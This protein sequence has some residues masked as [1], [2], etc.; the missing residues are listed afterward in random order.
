MPLLAFW[1]V[2]G[3]LGISQGVRSRGGDLRRPMTLALRRC[4]PTLFSEP[5]VSVPVPML[6]AQ[7]FHAHPLLLLS[8]F[9][10]F[11]LSLSQ[12]LFPHSLL[13]SLVELKGRGPRSFSFLAVT[14]LGSPVVFD[15]NKGEGALFRRWR[16]GGGWENVT[17]GM[18]NR[19][20]DSR[21]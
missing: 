18:R 7:S 14:T 21:G 13:S 5:G 15:S 2:P 3:S 20:R 8:L 17:R 16:L 19:C 11:H 10:P 6:R 1:L 4:W 12:H 9:S